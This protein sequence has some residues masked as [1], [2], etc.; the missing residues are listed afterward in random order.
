MILSLSRTRFTR[1]LQRLVPTI[2]AADLR[3]AFSGVRAQ[4]MR[5]DGSLETDFV[6]AAGLQALHLLNAPSPGA[7]AALA[8]ADEVL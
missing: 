1:E 7:T 4:G 5:A 3:P 8:I 6:F 2:Q